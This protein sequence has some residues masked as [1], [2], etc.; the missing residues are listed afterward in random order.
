MEAY[1]S[2][3]YSKIT[4]DDDKSPISS[5]IPKT[6]HPREKGLLLRGLEGKFLMGS[7]DIRAANQK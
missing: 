4:G 3:K 6:Y 1:F 7:Y 2:N 5:P